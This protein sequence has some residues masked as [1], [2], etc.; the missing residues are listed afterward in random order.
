MNIYNK[1]DY[2]FEYLIS[3]KNFSLNSVD[4]YKRDLMQLFNNDINIDLALITENYVV[5]TVNS[6]KELQTSNRSIAR[7]ISCYK[8]FFKFALEENW[9][10]NNPC[11][12][13]KTPKYVNKLPETLSINDINLLLNSSKTA[14][15]KEINNIRNNT[16]L[17]LIYGTGLRVSELVSMP[18]SAIN[19]NS[20][21]ILIKGKGKKERLVPISSSA[22]NAAIK[23][24]FLRNKMKTKENSKK[25]LFPANSNLGHI[26]RVQF[27]NIL[28]KISRHAGLINKKISPHVIRHAFATHL[29]SNGADLRIIQSLLGHSDIATT[30]IYTHVLEEQ[31]KSLVMKFHPFAKIK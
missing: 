5:N 24:L 18:L 31:K 7:K 1:L 29:L 13:L 20:E 4:A 10:N 30:Q 8:N 26:S 28:K 22:K 23:W 16:L 12:K 9:I 11:L 3:E 19:D 21:I 2:F 15:S 17:E 6:L 25:Y 27:F 14:D